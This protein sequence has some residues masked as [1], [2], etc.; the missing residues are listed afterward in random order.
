MVSSRAI[1]VSSR[2]YFRQYAYDVLD[3]I[4]MAESVGNVREV[5]KLTRILGHKERRVSCNPPKGADGRTITTSTQLLSEWEKFLG[6][7]FQRPAADARQNLESLPAEDVVLDN[8]ELRV[9]L[10]A[11]RSGK[12]TGW[13]NVPVE[14]YRGSVEAT[15][16]LFRICRLMWRTEQIPPD[17]VRGVFMMIYKKGPRDDFANYRV[18]RL[19]CYYPLSL[20]AY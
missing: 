18:I 16:E 2:D 10:K 19:L 11:L 5:S 7:K 9:C 15:N 13:D 12:A 3:D 6:T 1:A 20:L 4:E 8:D 17:L 14:A